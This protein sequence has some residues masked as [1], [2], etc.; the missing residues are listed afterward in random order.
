MSTIKFRKRFSKFMI[1][2]ALLGEFGRQTVISSVEVSNMIAEG[3][4]QDQLF[5]AIQR[6]IVL[7]CFY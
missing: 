1:T 6:T 5:N 2:I 4:E 7:A 3:G